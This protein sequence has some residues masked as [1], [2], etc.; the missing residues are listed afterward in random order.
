[1]RL[2]KA[3]VLIAMVVT[4]GCALHY[5]DSQGNHHY[6]GLLSI[7]TSAGECLDM[8]TATSAGLT[9]DLTDES[10][11]LNLGVRKVSKAY[12]RED[13]EPNIEMDDGKISAVNKHRDNARS[14]PT[15]MKN[16]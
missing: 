5:A 2:L 16:C 14:Q 8:V 1:M 10:A 9:L 7:K 15:A 3:L 12:I 11:G 13:N 4:S 6:L